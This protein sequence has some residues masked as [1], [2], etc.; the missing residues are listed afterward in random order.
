[1]CQTVGLDSLI[2]IICFSRKRPL[3]L[4]GYLTSLYQHCAG[5]FN[6][7]VLVKLDPDYSEP[8]AQLLDE[9]PKVVPR[10]ETEFAT[11]LEHALNWDA[12]FTT[13]ACDDVIYTTH[14]EPDAI[15]KV[16]DAKPELLGVSLRL[17]QNIHADMFGQPL[18]PPEISDLTWDMTASTS[19]G[20][21]AYPWEVLGTVYRTD[22]VKRMVANLGARSPSQLEERG[23]RAWAAHDPS[24][25]Y[26]G[27]DGMRWHHMAMYPTSRLVV[28]TVNVIQTEFPGNGTIGEPM[29]PEF[30]LD[31]WNNGLRMDTERYKG[32]E[33][34]SWRIGNFYLR[35]AMI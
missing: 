10:Y 4:H 32:M 27:K 21:W 23:A 6:V 1:M 33:P 11:D 20:D 9:F 24:G 25:L 22:F 7:A 30:L 3:Q 18:M 28:P 35:R 19:V 26:A 29:S 15:G 8:Y 31:C 13:F 12:E 2:Q 17:G 34:P 14:F 5:D 16:M